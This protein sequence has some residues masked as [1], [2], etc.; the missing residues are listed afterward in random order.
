M[1]FLFHSLR[2][3]LYLFCLFYTS[4]IKK[5][6]FFA[7]TFY[8]WTFFKHNLFSLC[9]FCA[10]QTM[11]EHFFRFWCFKFNLFFEHV[12]RCERK[13]KK[14]SGKQKEFNSFSRDSV[15]YYGFLPVIFGSV[16][17]LPFHKKFDCLLTHIVPCLTFNISS[18][19]FKALHC[20]AP[21]YKAPFNAHKHSLSH[22]Q[23][24]KWYLRLWL[25]LSNHFDCAVAKAFK[26]LLDK[27][28]P[29]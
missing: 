15:S 29:K 28:E 2:S 22:F 11:D 18:Y 6:E 14:P 27:R 8:G 16:A 20:V 9:G 25:I 12:L 24:I 19:I 5:F 7:R 13:G 17:F 26:R 10:M 21:H 23:S 4:Q 3:P 1:C